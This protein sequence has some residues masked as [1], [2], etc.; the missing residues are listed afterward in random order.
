MKCD[1]FNGKCEV[2]SSALSCAAR[3]G[4]LL[5]NI[6]GFLGGAVQAAPVTLQVD[7]I[8][9]P[10]LL[11]FD[12]R[13]PPSWNVPLQQG[14][15]ISATFTFDPFDAPS[16]ISYTK[17]FE[18]YDFTFHIKSQTLTTAQ[19][20]IEVYNNSY[21]IDDEG[22]NPSDDI[23]IGCAAG[24]NTPSCVPAVLTTPDQLKWSFQMIIGGNPSVLD[25]ADI[26]A[27]ATIWQEL[28]SEG[29]LV[30]LFTDNA[31]LKSYGFRAS[32]RHFNNIPEPSSGLMLLIGSAAVTFARSLRSKISYN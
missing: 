18:P 3:C 6:L 23:Y 15:I 29:S 25:G 22:I 5:A 1:R 21:G 11:N 19:Y 14:D 28:S 9:G 31:A 24:I 32:P 8:V 20:G 10:P 2:F 17:V 4:I 7:A 16:N 26:P 13:L 30:V 27:V 12:G